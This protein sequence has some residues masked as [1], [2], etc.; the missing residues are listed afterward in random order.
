MDEERP[1][2]LSKL[3]ANL[4]LTIV[5]FLIVIAAIG[6]NLRLSSKPKLVILGT[7]TDRIFLRNIDVYQQAAQK[8][9]ANSAFNSNKATFDASG[10]SREL[11]VQF[12]ELAAVSVSLPLFGSQP[13]IYI[14]PVDPQLIMQNT[15]GERFILDDT[16]RVLATDTSN[17]THGVSFSVPTIIDQSGLP[18]SVG[19]L[20]LPNSTVSYITEVAGQLHASSVGVTNYILPGG[21]A[22]ELD[23]QLTGKGYVVRFNLRGDPRIEVGDYLASAH[24]IAQNNRQVSQYID[25]RVD[26]RSYFK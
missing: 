22:S 17:V 16:G 6:A 4:T 25:V 20:A 24:Y 2:R 23:A 9:L 13:T 11:H 18:I 7:S 8:D 19:K 15:S 10:V 26:G 3:R 14:L 21:G 1:R 5:I 12:P